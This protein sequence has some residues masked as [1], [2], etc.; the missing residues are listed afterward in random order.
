MNVQALK[1][2]KCSSAARRGVA[3]G[4]SEKEVGKRSETEGERERRRERERREYGGNDSVKM[5]GR[6]S[7]SARTLCETSTELRSTH[8]YARTG[9]S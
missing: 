9:A 7:V 2:A 4:R 6:L 8:M 3:R 5:R 1:S